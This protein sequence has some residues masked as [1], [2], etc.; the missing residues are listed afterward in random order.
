MC[1]YLVRDP[2][3][4]IFFEWLINENIYTHRCVNIAFK[5]KYFP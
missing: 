5:L 3:I 2:E 1:L 4:L